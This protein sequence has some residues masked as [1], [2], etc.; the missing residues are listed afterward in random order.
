MKVL[1]LCLLAIVAVTANIRIPLKKRPIT[2][3]H[4]VSFY[5]NFR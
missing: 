1:F 3:D 4:S 5:N 2:L